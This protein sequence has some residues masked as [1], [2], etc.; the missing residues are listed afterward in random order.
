MK[1]LNLGPSLDS[2][3]GHDHDD[4]GDHDDHADHD[5]HDHRGLRLG[6][7]STAETNTTWDQVKKPKKKKMADAEIPHVDANLQE[8]LTNI[9]N[10]NQK[11]LE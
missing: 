6:Q 5:H 1:S 2:E 3:A 11:Y 7:K 10:S 8:Q 9:N 4:H